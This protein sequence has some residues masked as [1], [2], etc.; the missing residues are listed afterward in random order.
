MGDKFGFS[1]IAGRFWGVVCEDPLDDVMSSQHEW[2]Q[3]TGAGATA[4]DE[5]WG[6]G[7]PPLECSRCVTLLECFHLR[8]LRQSPLCMQRCAGAHL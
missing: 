5:G 6:P 1:S 3:G 8:P 7:R 2:H 4:P